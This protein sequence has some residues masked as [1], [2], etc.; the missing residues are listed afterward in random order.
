MAIV[1]P[2]WVKDAVFYQVFPDRFARSQ[3]V[4][5]PAN[6]EP[7][8]SP[9]TTQ[10]FK[11]GDLIGVVER[12]DYLQD[13]GVNA[14]YF[15]PVFQSASNHRYHTH[16]YYQVD[17]ILGGN[18]ALRRLLDESHR[19]GMHIVLD[20]VFNHA[21]RGFYQFNHLLELGPHSPYVDWFSVHEWPIDGYGSGQPNY[22]AWW[23][24]PALPKF[25]TNTPAVR[26]FLWG[27]G[28]HW[29]EQG[30]DGWRLDVA[31]E[32]DD[33]AFW[34][35][36]RRRVK[37]ANPDA[38]IVAEIWH[39]ARRWLQGDQYDATMNYLFNKACIAFFAG[40]DMD[41]PLT[42]R[43]G[44]SPIHPLD[45]P[46]FAMFVD[47]T[48]GLYDWQINL[49]QLSLLGSH[50][51]A[52]FLSVARGDESALRLATLYQMAYPGPP[53][54]YY[55]DE[56]GLTGG[57]DPECRAAMP[58]DESVWNAGLRGYFKK[59]IA[60]RHNHAALRRGEYRQ[61]CADGM[62]YA[63]ARR[64]G[65][66]TLVVALN[67]GRATAALEIPVAGLLADGTR[68][69]HIFQARGSHTVSGGFVH[70][71]SLPPRSGVVLGAASNHP[72]HESL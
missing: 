36:F 63:F 28:Q 40:D 55:G 68:L 48:L 70:D 2:D 60:L 17:P 9:P 67:A 52:R 18:A 15:N 21:S 34:Q 41:R 64:W 50:D 32:I 43:K 7:W 16:D 59:C 66:E 65:E 51:T 5:K 1:T 53:S 13:L 3:S 71:L 72:Q 26:E 62:L 23:G 14:I 24:L 47:D 49:A 31:A 6:L 11:G 54:I 57:N 4:P 39:E 61:L 33:D 38:Y 58:W 27:V 56:I 19:R 25:N 10:G 35:E 46:G 37:R 29:I 12:L 42:E 8:D 30:V 45:A 44:Y 69:E 20:G 22:S